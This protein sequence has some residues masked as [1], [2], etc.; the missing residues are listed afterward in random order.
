MASSTVL[1]KP[2][3]TETTGFNL[4]QQIFRYHALHSFLKKYGP[5]IP[6]PHRPHQTVHFC[7]CSGS[8]LNSSGC[9]SA[10]IRHNI[11]FESE[12]G[13]IAE[14]NLPIKEGIFIE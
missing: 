7:G 2:K 8:S 6:P 14:Q 5:M 4:W 10:Q 12:M 11:P 9:S 1:L 13:L 3:F